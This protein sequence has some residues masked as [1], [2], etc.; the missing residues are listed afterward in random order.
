MQGFVRNPEGKRPPG[1]TRRGWEDNIGIHLQQ[2]GYRGVDCID[3]FQDKNRW[4]AL[5]NAVMDI[6][7][8]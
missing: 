4:R 5:V 7:V 8:P 3:H 6:R 2:M 1:R